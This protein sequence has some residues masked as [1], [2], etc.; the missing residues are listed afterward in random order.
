[1]IAASSFVSARR[2]KRPRLPNKMAAMS[3]ADTPPAA[4]IASRC[5]TMRRREGG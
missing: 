1:L 3:A 2:R 4:T 5:R